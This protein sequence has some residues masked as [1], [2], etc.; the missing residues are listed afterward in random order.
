MSPDPQAP[1]GYTLTLGGS[2]CAAVSPLLD[3]SYELVP[4]CSG[5]LCYYDRDLGLSSWELPAGM[6]G[7]ALPVLAPPP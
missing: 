2:S 4:E 5:A 3:S 1:T 7:V 6:L